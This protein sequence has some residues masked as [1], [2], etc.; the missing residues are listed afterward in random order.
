MRPYVRMI[1]VGVPV[2]AWAF[3]VGAVP[4]RGTYERWQQ[5][6]TEHL[7]IRVIR[8]EQVIS[9]NGPIEIEA[10]ATIT[11]I[12]RSTTQLALGDGI[13]IQYAQ[14][15]KGLPLVTGPGD[16]TTLSIEEHYE[17]YLNQSDWLH[18]FKPAAAIRSF[19]KLENSDLLRSIDSLTAQKTQLQA[20]MNLLAKE[21]ES[22]ETPDESSAEQ[23]CEGTPPDYK[24]TRLEQLHGIVEARLTE[25]QDQLGAQRVEQEERPNRLELR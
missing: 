21:T 23:D 22:L 12:H 25:L 24:M 10:E 20:E 4:P 8:V 14:R 19:N 13:V 7:N 18:G 11:K 1:F 5:Q 16:P 9:A 15:S 6:A 2:L 17:V 3:V